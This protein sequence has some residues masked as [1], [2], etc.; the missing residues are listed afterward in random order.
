MVF[1]EVEVEVEVE[2]FFSSESMGRRRSKRE[3]LFSL[4]SRTVLGRHVAH[5]RGV[6]EIDELGR[7]DELVRDRGG[8]ERAGARRETKKNRR[9]KKCE[10]N[11]CF[12]CQKT[13]S[14]KKSM[15][16]AD[17]ALALALQLEEEEAA[18]NEQQQAASHSN[19]DEVARNLTYGLT[20]A[21]KVRQTMKKKKKTLLLRPR[22]FF[23]STHLLSSFSFS[24]SFALH[25]TAPLPRLSGSCASRHAHRPPPP[26]GETGRN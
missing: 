24:V 8:H 19:R 7:E 10:R 6:D 11:H 15:E 1:W 20:L 26:G 9:R 23:L 25:T 18:R 17:A 13:R 4:L 16:D 3:S 5:P 12:D 14:K 22:R 2:I 21:A